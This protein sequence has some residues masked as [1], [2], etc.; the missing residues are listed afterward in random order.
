MQP[1]SVSG[2]RVLV[3]GASSGI[4]AALVE[5]LQR[6][7]ARVALVARTGQRLRALAAATDVVLAGDLTDPAF[8]AGL[9]QRAADA[10]GGLDIVINNAGVGLYQPATGASIDLARIMFELNFFTPLDLCQQAVTVFRRQGTPAVIVNV[11]SMAGEMALPWFTLYCASKYAL[12]ALTAGLRME[13]AKANIGVMNVVPGY[14]TTAFQENVLGGEPP[15][16]VRNAKRFAVSAEQCAGAIVSGI[17]HGKRKVVSPWAGRLLTA[18]ATVLP[19]VVES[20]LM[21]MNRG[22]ERGK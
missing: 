19:S 3:T 15:R 1:L 7:G 22:G 17:E 2:K 21:R 8:R 16:A 11:S 20:H 5:L 4:G 13:L 18:F 12:A 10:L 6:R 9:V 14:V